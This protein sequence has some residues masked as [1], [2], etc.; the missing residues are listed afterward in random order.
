MESQGQMLNALAKR[1]AGRKK[2][3]N[4]RTPIHKLLAKK[5]VV[6][7]PWFH[8][9]F[10]SSKVPPSLCQEKNF[11]RGVDWRKFL[12]DWWLNHSGVL[13]QQKLLTR[14]RVLPPPPDP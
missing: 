14:D 6:V 8:Q 4:L 2:V 9:D 7:P 13:I 12:E 1:S 5:R 3:E 11:S 10:L